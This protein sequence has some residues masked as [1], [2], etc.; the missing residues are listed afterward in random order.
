MF[1]QINKMVAQPGQ[2]SELIGHLTAG[3]AHMP[4]C[5][6]YIVAADAEHADIIWVTE[7]WDSPDLHAASLDIT[8]VRSAISA[9]MPFIASFETVATTAPILD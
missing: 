5:R 1:G 3:T 8:E 4:G 7:V 9:A 2:R 6:S